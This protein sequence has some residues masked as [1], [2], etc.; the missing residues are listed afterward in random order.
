MLFCLVAC[1]W[2]FSVLA[3]TNVI[4]INSGFKLDSDGKKCVDIN[5]CAVNN[6]GCSGNCENTVGSM[7][8]S[9]QVFSQP[10][11]FSVGSSIM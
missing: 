9:C 6:G 11:I 4:F 7:F 1:K 3:I 5:E 8:C 10:L 2:T